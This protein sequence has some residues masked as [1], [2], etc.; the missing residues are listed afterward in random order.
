[1][2]S[3]IVMCFFF[4][5]IRRPPRSTRTDTLFPYTP[6]FR[7]NRARHRQAEEHVRA[8]HRVG[9]RPVGGL[10]CMS[11]FPLVHAFG[12]ALVD[13]ALGIAEYDVVGHYAH[14]LRQ[15]GIGD[16]GSARAVDDDLDVFHPESSEERRVGKECVRTCSSRCREGPEKKN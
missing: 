12:A 9:E 6:L 8:A 1:M 14:R 10:R 7:S 16:G 3:S 5:M 4:L 15:F 11:G 13:H 2:W